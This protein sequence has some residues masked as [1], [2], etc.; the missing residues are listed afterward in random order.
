MNRLPG[1]LHDCYFNHMYLFVEPLGQNC[2]RARHLKCPVAN[3]T[4]FGPSLSFDNL[5]VVHAPSH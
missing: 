3:C 1:K 5:T 4:E 2:T